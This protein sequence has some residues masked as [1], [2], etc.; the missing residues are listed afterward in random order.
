MTIAALCDEYVQNGMVGKK[1]STIKSDLSRIA[2]HIKPALGKRKVI[3]VTQEDVEQF[4]QGMKPASAKRVAGLLGAIFTY[5]IKRKLR[6]DNPV[7]GVEKPADVKKTRRLSDAE[8]QQL[9]G[10]LQ[11]G[12]L[13]NTVSEAILM[14][15]VTGWRSGEVTNLKFY[16][17]D[18]ERRIAVL[19]DTKTGQSVRPLSSA[20]IETIKRQP[21]RDGQELVFEHRHAKAISD[22]DHWFRKL[23]M[24]KTITPHT[25]R[26]SFASLG[27]IEPQG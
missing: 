16:E 22:M 15:A 18:L 24:D 6:A 26:H 19:G 13:A 7:H 9:W 4:M 14:L 17:V 10:A 23:G 3:G 12:A 1:A 27:R 21:V 8:Y 2:T 25:L 5:S 11:N 20:A